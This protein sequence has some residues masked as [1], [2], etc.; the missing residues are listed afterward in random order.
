[1][2]DIYLPVTMVVDNHEQAY[3]ALIKPLVAWIKENGNSIIF[4]RLEMSPLKN[5]EVLL[6]WIGPMTTGEVLQQW[7][8]ISDAANNA[9]KKK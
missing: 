4:W 3:K 2:P 8:L 1:M 6:Q 5:R 7:Y 9:T